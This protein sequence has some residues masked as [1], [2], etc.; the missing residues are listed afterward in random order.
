MSF[1]LFLSGSVVCF[2]SAAVHGIWGRKIYLGLIA[3]TNL[4]AR[5][6]SISAV[7]W[8]VFTVMLLTSGACLLFV[9]FNRQAIWM[10]YPIMI[11]H[12]MGAGVFFLS[13]AKGNKELIALPGAYLMS[14]IGLLTLFAL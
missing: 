13:I 6:K 3:E 14:A 8:D 1:Y 11:I 5:E 4:P 2:F 7:S 10:A 12:F 9:A